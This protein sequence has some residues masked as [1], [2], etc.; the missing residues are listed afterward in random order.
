MSSSSQEI[1]M[2]LQ[3]KGAWKSKPKS[4]RQYSRNMKRS[5]SMVKRNC[6]HEKEEKMCLEKSKNG[7]PMEMVFVLTK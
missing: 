6:C 3:M 4:G 7:L 2:I 1:M 5:K